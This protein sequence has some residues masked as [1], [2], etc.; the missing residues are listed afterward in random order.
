MNKSSKNQ[1]IRRIAES[2]I[3]LALATIL[4]ELAVFKLPYGGSVTF[5]SQV[6]M[7]VISYRYGVKWGAFSG[8]VMG[9]IQLFFGM[10][11]F[12]YVSGIPAY[13]ILIFADYVIAFG[14]L[15][16]GGM[17][18]NRIKNDA[19]AMALG[20]GVVTAIRFICHFISGVTIWGDYSN[21]SMGAVW[22]SITY[23][24]SYMLPELIITIIGC[25]VIGGVFDV[26]STEIKAKAGKKQ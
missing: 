24:G 15:G 25:A 19:V 13:L 10:G 11:N 8:L 18:R 6:P 1:K 5:F 20:G 23:N 4:S 7:I 26:K 17:F 21:G 2:A 14:V 12:S 16:L 9:V 3:M 22:Y